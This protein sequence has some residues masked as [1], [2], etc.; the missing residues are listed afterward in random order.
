MTKFHCQP[1]F[2]TDLSDNWEVDADDAKTAAERFQAIYDAEQG[3]EGGVPHV[4]V[5]Y[6]DGRKQLFE[7]QSK[8]LRE[9]AAR[10]AT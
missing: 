1:V 8:V 3:Y 7:L 9:Y 10:A 4:R 5:I 6:P 2:Y